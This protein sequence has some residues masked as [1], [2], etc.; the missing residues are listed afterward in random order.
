VLLREK[1]NALEYAIIALSAVGAALIAM[2][3]SSGGGP[4]PT[5]GG[6]LLVF[7]S[8]FAA[9]VMIVPW[10]IYAARDIDMGR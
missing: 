9:T 8:M 4:Q 6:D 3:K 7:V 10:H 5:A 1:L 2:A